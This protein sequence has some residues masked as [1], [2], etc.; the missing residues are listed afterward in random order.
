M[1]DGR[2]HREP[3]RVRVRF[4]LSP[5]EHVADMLITSLCLFIKIRIKINYEI[6]MFNIFCNI[7][8]RLKAYNFLYM[9]KKPI[10]Q[11]LIKA[12]TCRR[13]AKSCDY[14]WT[15]VSKIWER[16][17]FLVQVVYLS[18]RYMYSERG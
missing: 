11:Q 5:L 12:E 16:N 17:L 4:P 9:T 3:I 6:H 8:G 10:L 7:V 2:H 15:F 18:H 13:I 14:V 1:L